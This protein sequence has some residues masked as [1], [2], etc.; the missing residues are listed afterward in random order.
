MFMD[1]ITSNCFSWI[2]LE[3]ELEGQLLL[4][5]LIAAEVVSRGVNRGVRLLIAKLQIVRVLIDKAIK[6]INNKVRKVQ[7]HQHRQ[8]QQGRS[9]PH[10]HRQSPTQPHKQRAIS[11]PTPSLQLKGRT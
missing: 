11:A 8:K 6:I 9:H 7:A 4:E 10:L 5:L 2:R 1:L 3:E